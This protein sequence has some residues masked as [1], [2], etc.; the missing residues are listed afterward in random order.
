MLNNNNPDEIVFFRHFIDSFATY[1]Y[2]NATR[3]FFKA[4]CGVRSRSVWGNNLSVLETTDSAIREVGTVFGTHRHGMVLNELWIRELWFEVLLNDLMHI[5]FCG[6]HMLTCG[7][8]FFEIGRGISL[9][10]NYPSM[11]PA[12]GF[13]IDTQID[14]YAF[15]AKLSG[16]LKK[17]AFHMIS[18]ALFLITVRQ[19]LTRPMHVFDHMNLVIA[20]MA[21][22]V[23]VLLI[24]LFRQD[25][26]GIR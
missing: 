5:P 6:R 17:T 1:T 16:E 14:Q 10:A 23:L 18:I 19:H 12:I 25:Y 4:K 7:A 22:A 21:L 11:P 13:F 15:G 24:I 8:F 2:G 9:G 20:A 26:S 3:Q